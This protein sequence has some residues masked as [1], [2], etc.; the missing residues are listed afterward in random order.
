M[1]KKNGPKL[2]D[3]MFLYVHKREVVLL[4]T[5]IAPEYLCSDSSPSPFC[6]SFLI[7]V[8]SFFILS[9]F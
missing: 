9:R 3:K 7:H 4:L 5:F 1:L 2:R 8:F 6:F